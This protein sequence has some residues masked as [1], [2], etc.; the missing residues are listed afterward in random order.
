MTSRLLGVIVFPMFSMKGDVMDIGMVGLGRMGLNMALR[1]SKAGHKIV[2]YDPDEEARKSV[3]RD[4]VLA[5]SSL[6]ELMQTLKPPRFIWVMVPSG[7]ITEQTIETLST[8]LDIGDVVIDGGNSNYKDSVRRGSYLLEA[9]IGF[10]DVGTSGGVWGLENGYS[11]M[12]GGDRRIFEQLEPI[13]KALAPGENIGYGLVGPSGSGH[14]VKMIHNGIEYGL[15]Q[16]YAEGFELMNAKEEYGLDLSQISEIWRH[17]SVVRSWLLD[18]TAEALS[19]DKN[20]DSVKPY[21]EDSGEGR[22]TVQESIELSVPAPVIALALQ[23]RF[24]SRQDNSFGSRL[25]AYM[26]NKFGGHAVRKA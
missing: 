3:E 20:L 12:V 24:R 6:Q 25:L 21:V 14:F 8:G 4:G 19:E 26:R 16:A 11:I 23:M 13:F 18:L 15:M 10:L 22:W 7:S 17:G 9:G 2:A 5:V 1:I